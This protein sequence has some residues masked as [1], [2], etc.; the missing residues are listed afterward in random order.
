MYVTAHTRTLISRNDFHLKML[1]FEHLESEVGENMQL[2]AWKKQDMGEIV[3]VTGDNFSQNDRNGHI[4]F[5][6]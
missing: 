5:E 2:K 3:K 6:L 1:C 4:S